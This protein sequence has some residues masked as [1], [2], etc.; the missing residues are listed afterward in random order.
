[1]G[2]AFWGKEILCWGQALSSRT[3]QITELLGLANIS[4][5]PENLFFSSF[6]F[7]L[8]KKKSVSSNPEV[9][10]PEENI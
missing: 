5:S 9:E 2:E 6:T 8:E 3:E 4:G 1:M 10:R 7:C